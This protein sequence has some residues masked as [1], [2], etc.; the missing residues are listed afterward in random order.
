[1]V[2]NNDF[3]LIE[4]LEKL[5]D[6]RIVERS[7]HKLVDIVTITVVAV[8]AGA[9][10]WVD[11]ESFGNC[12]H[13]WLRT[14][15]ELPNG[16]PSHDTFGRLFKI[17]DTARFS[18]LFAAW[19]RSVFKI[20]AGEIVAIDGKTVRRS[21]DKSD[22]KAAIHMVNAWA[23][24][25]GVSLGQ[26]RT[27]A[28]SNEITAIPELLAILDLKGCIVTTDAMGCQKKIAENIRENEADY[29]L[30]VKR[31]QKSLYEDIKAIF[32]ELPT[33]DLREMGYQTHE[34]IDGDH[35]RVE[36]RQYYLLSDISW[37]PNRNDWKDLSS[38][39]MVRSK[40]EIDGKTSIDS[41]F[42]ITSLKEVKTFASS[43]RGHWGVENNLHWSLD[44]TFR[45]DENRTRKGNAAANLAIIRQMALN[46]LK[47]EKSLKV[48]IKA[49]RNKA[50]WD[51]SYL[52]KVLGVK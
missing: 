19:T 20:T 34:T 23:V 18:K 40:R 9:D 15:L 22:S 12:K 25:T 44:V 1:M 28:K 6:P 31:N 29:V 13:D 17:L 41:R 43:V 2:A 4:C 14:F 30:A 16:I 49:K 38:I 37:L 50:G 10:S 11:I 21:H 36:T 47:Q 46:L 45:E 8:I 24:Q 35:G 27:A 32:T 39:G 3:S 42:Y 51:N 48:G 5:D 52:L 26:K 33:E 7:D